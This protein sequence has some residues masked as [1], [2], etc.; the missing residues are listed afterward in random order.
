MEE[1]TDKAT[2]KTYTN[3]KAIALLKARSRYKASAKLEALHQNLSNQSVS[4][5][6]DDSAGF[7]VAVDARKA[8]KRLATHDY[9]KQDRAKHNKPYRPEVRP[10]RA[11]AEKPDTRIRTHG[12]TD[13]DTCSY[14]RNKHGDNMPKE[15]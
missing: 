8:M 4:K 5:A 6:S 13:R 11:H 14:Y 10:F 9:E 15:R 12:K 7:N 1:Y 3:P 2:G